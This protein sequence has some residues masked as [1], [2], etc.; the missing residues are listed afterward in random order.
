MKTG[1]WYM[2]RDESD[3]S[4]ICFFVRRHGAQSFGA[5][6]RDNYGTSERFIG[7]MEGEKELRNTGRRG[8]DR[9][10]RNFRPGES[11]RE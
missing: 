5:G 11:S 3:V 6:D 1:G 7:T 10:G 8:E 2:A 4:E 9:R